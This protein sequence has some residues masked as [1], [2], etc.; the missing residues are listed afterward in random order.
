MYK[1]INNQP[2][3][4]QI[5]AFRMTKHEDDSF[6]NYNID[7]ATITPEQIDALSKE[8]GIDPEKIRDEQK[9]TLSLPSE[10]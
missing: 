10:I 1:L 8:F 2:T 6:M 5:A 9:L 7:L 3:E 4:E